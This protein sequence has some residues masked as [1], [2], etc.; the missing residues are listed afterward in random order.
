MGAGPEDT[1][2]GFSNPSSEIGLIG[3]TPLLYLSGDR[4]R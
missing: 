3:F 1:A 2:L 4:D